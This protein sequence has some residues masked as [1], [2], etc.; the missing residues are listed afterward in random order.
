MNKMSL[1]VSFKRELNV[2]F[3]FSAALSTP[4]EKET[5]PAFS[6]FLFL[7]FPPP[8]ASPPSDLFPFSSQTQLLF[9]FCPAIGVGGGEK[10]KVA[11][12]N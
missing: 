11:A 3:F 12:S 5:L 7:S 9:S 4:P 1:F 10:E 8:T 2:Y 6:L